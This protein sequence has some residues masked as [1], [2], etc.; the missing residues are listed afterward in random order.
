MSIWQRRGRRRAG[1]VANRQSVLI[2]QFRVAMD[3]QVRLKRHV[4]AFDALADLVQFLQPSRRVVI[5]PIRKRCSSPAF[6]DVIHN[7]PGNGRHIGVPRPPGAVRV[8]VTAGAVEQGGNVGRQMF[9]RRQRLARIDGRVRPCRPHQLTDGEKGDHSRA[10]SLRKSCRV[11]RACI[12][13]G[14][15]RPV[16][17][18]R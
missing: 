2:A 4:M 11:Q 8:A 16:A 17:H 14:S 10:G 5:G 3:E 9:V 12:I 13:Y 6:V 18:R 1:P 15:L 7:P